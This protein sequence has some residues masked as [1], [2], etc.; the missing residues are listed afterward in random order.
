MSPRDPDEVRSFVFLALFVGAI[1]MAAALTGCV[2]VT[3]S[4]SY[5]RNETVVQESGSN[6]LNKADIG[7]RP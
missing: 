5:T 7:V 1:I 3:D 2:W 6:R 4:S